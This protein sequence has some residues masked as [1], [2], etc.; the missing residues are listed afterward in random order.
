VAVVDLAVGPDDDLFAKA[1]THL[2][3]ATNDRAELANCWVEICEAKGFDSNLVIEDGRGRLDVLAEWPG[4]SLVRANEA[5]G[6]FAR[7]L[8][9][10]YDEAI[11]AGAR[12]VSGGVIDPDP[13]SHRMLFCT[14][15]D[16]FAAAVAGGALSGLRP[17]QIRGVSTFQPFGDAPGE[18]ELRNELRKQMAH[19]SEM[20]S[21]AR[22]P[23][24]PRVAVWA[25]S[26]RPLIEVHPAGATVP[27]TSTGDGVLV[28]VRTV[29]TFVYDGDSAD[30]LANPDLAFDM[31][32][33]DQPWPEDPDDNLP[34]RSAMMLASA[35]EFVRAMERSVALPPPVHAAPRRMASVIRPLAGTEWTPL[36]VDAF[37]D[38]E[39][40]EA[41]MAS[42]DLGLAIHSDGDGQVTMLVRAGETTFCRPVP[43]ALP[44]DPAIRQGTA[45][46]DASLDAASRWGLPD[47]VMRP[48][49][50][51]KGKASRE[52][53]DGTIITG[54]RGVSVQVK[55][56]EAPG[57]D[58]SRE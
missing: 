27:C 58:P 9:L 43:A 32:F 33:N 49:V 19:L 31:I 45:A 38:A 22:A 8:S 21:P 35:R 56:R 55:S 46:E 41:A 28:D 11:L 57:N 16:E 5:A 26:A 53:G 52:V 47:F 29:A 2:D 51:V 48:S 25:H 44:L 4:D 18:S 40:V 10:A 3:D 6:R 37:P 30:L 14:S 39:A 50:I 15:E 36:D 54:R 1:W 20:L 23:D 42:S 12:H 7:N 34:A 17:D 13:A 24:R